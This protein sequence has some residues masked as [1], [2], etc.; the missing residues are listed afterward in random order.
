MNEQYAYTMYSN[1]SF[2]QVVKDLEKAAVKHQFRVLYTHD[3]QAT[4]ADKGFKRE[5]LKIVE[6]CNARF[7]HEALE[8]T[9]DVALFMP[10]RYAVYMEGPRTVV[11]LARPSVIGEMI[12][13]ADLQDMATSVETTLKE[14]MHEVL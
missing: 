2:D 13:D 9:N 1:K 6:V 3:V 12:R 8:K 11:S 7:A 10:C 5:P 14:I 4:L